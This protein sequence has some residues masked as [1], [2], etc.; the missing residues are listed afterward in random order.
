MTLRLKY[1]EYRATENGIPTDMKQKIILLVCAATFAASPAWATLVTWELNP[2]NLNQNVGSSSRS[3]TISGLTGLPG[4]QT[5]A[6]IIA[7]GY[8]NV[9]GT[10]TPHDLFYKSTGPIGGASEHGLGI[11]GTDDNELGLKADGSPAQYI[12]LDLRSILGQGFTGG[13]VEVGSVQAGES[14]KLF[15]SNTQGTLGT[16]LGSTF[17]ASF[18]EKFVAVP[19]FGTFQF[20]SIAAGTG[21]VLPIAFRA[22]FP[23]V[24]EMNALLPILG[25]ITA[26][27]STTILRRRRASR[28]ES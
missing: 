10:N 19:N 6:S 17:G 12:Q 20:I 14:F 24:P 9:T 27:S 11:V 21:D 5:Q 22:N 8:D 25:L 23:P 15:G 4:G 3:Y 1:E 16:Q 18:D 7:R 2:S 13:E 28:I 26:I